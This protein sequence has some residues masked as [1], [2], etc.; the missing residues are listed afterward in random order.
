MSSPMGEPEKKRARAER[1]L[2]HL[3]KGLWK[4]I[5]V[6]GPL[7]DEL[8][9]EQFKEAL[10]G[11]VDKLSL[12]QV[13]ELLQTFPSLDAL[14]GF[15]RRMAT[16]TEEQRRQFCLKAA[17]IQ[18]ALLA[19]FDQVEEHLETLSGEFGNVKRMLAEFL[20]NEVSIE[21]LERILAKVDHQR[22]E[23]RQRISVNQRRLLA[24]IPREFTPL[25]MLWERCISLI[26][27]CG[28]K[29]FRFRLHELEWLA[30]V[31][32]CRGTA[33]WEYRRVVPD[34]RASYAGQ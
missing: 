5:P 12:A 1:V 24:R 3:G 22:E 25:A 30:L 28:Y 8:F 33:D 20:E 32:R 16:L 13:Q 27:Q 34:E 29:E 21:Q 9:Y 15:E 31:E 19:G 2:Y 10:N 14:D 4:A 17:E 18:D 23:W 26:P 7:V 11:Q 6:V